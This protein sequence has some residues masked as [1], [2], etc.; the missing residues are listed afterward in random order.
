M[1]CASDRLINTHGSNL[2]FR[3]F[4]P[5][6]AAYGFIVW[7]KYQVFSKAA[8]IFFAISAGNARIRRMIVYAVRRMRP[9]PQ[10][11]W[12]EDRI[13]ENVNINQWL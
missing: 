5:K 8:N 11:Q 2:C 7:K 9:L 6:L 12:T 1:P 10:K 3:P 4:S 13:S